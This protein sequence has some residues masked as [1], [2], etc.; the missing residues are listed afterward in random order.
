MSLLRAAPYLAV[1][2]P[3]A[4]AGLLLAGIRLWGRASA[5]LA[6]IGPLLAAAVGAASLSGGSAGRFAWMRAGA[7]VLRIGYRV[8]G[9]SAVMLLV[10][11]V[12]AACVI[13]F[14]IGYMRGDRLPS[15]GFMAIEALI[16][17]D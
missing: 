3:L 4:I 13:V 1:A 12:V 9:L 10:V 11:G 8:D 17:L 16:F 2:A 15:A 14:S 5:W 7:S 6:L